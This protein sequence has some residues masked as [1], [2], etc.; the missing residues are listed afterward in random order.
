VIGQVIGGRYAIVRLLGEGAMGSVYEAKHTSSG[1]RVAL[2]VISDELVGKGQ[3]RARFA[4]E[5]QA[6]AAIESE[7]VVHILD[8]GLD[9][10]HQAP[11][12]AMELLAGE[13]LD[14]ALSRL[15]ALSPEVTARLGVQACLGLEKAHA[16]G[17]LHRDLKP[18]NI[19]LARRDGGEVKVKLVDFGIAKLLDA[20]GASSKLTRTGAILGSP[21]YMSPEQAYARKDLD[22][23]SDLWS[24]G[25]VLYECLTGSAPFADLDSVPEL[26]V[27]IGT[28]AAPPLRA[29]APHVPEGLAAL[30]ESTL[31]IERGVRPP[32]ATALREAL[33]PF[34]GGTWTLH[35]AMLVPREA[36]RAEAA[37]VSAGAS[38]RDAE[39][40]TEHAP[41][42]PATPA[43]T[44]A[45]RTIAAD[46]SLHALAR[47][48]STL[49]DEGHA[50]HAGLAVGAPP[51]EAPRALAASPSAPRSKSALP[52]VVL[53]VVAAGGAGLGVRWALS[54][55]EARAS[56]AP[57][58]SAP[59]KTASS[60][61][62]GPTSAASSSATSSAAGG[63]ATT[64]SAAST[65][66]P[67]EPASPSKSALT[68]LVGVWTSSTGRDYDA[69]PS[70]EGLELRI[71]RGADFRGQ[72][73]ADGEVRFL[74]R[75]L[76][77]ESA[78]FA[79]EDHLRPSSPRELPF[80][81][82][83]RAACL[84]TLSEVDGKPLRARLVRDPSGRDKLELDTLAVVTSDANFEAKAGRVTAC[85]G[86]DKLARRL[87]A[88]G[89]TRKP[90]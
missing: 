89:L 38:S 19:F 44:P 78:V 56:A 54:R 74:L 69:V 68:A 21:L 45:T 22:A 60:S 53:G 48:S 16:V 79:V 8:A 24:L 26:L 34:A 71:Q 46:P 70:A 1:R 72:G 3:V 76:P 87:K 5:A 58:A 55:D 12:I 30:I 85:K 64:G 88:S 66:S 4:L 35:E 51:A 14:G 29:R 80:E 67:P 62:P 37:V 18:A 10:A 73:Y 25:V 41:R 49:V 52:W 11:F 84:L 9:D 65:P 33:L 61:G 32:S 39:R 31:A 13:D 86:L 28:R 36:V 27:A 82:D 43:P 59:T 77:G 47:P 50:G 90:R 15:G 20:D 63:S 57:E 6:A 7:H 17:I 40:P 75:E 42:A 83:A 81:P 2:K 23:R